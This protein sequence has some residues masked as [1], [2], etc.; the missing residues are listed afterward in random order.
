[1]PGHRPVLAQLASGLLAH[2]ED[3]TTEALA[4]VLRRP[5]ASGELEHLARQLTIP[6]P[7]GPVTVTTQC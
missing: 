7:E 3:I 1:M 4:V 6:W 5:A 2:A